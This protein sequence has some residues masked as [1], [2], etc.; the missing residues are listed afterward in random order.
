[1]ADLKTPK[2]Y[3][4]QV[5]GLIE[6]HNLVIQ[7]EQ[8]AMN[9]LSSVNYYRLSAYGIGLKKKDN[10]EHYEDGISF[11]HLYRLYEFD[12]K[13]RNLITPVIE[14]IEVEFRTRLAY[15]LALAYGAEGY[16]DPANFSQKTTKD[17][18][19]IHAYTI[20]KLDEEISH[21][22][23][24]PF[25]K[26]HMTKYGGH[27][28]IWA[29]AELFTFGMSCSLYDVCQVEDKKAIAATYQTKYVYLFAWMLS[30]SELR[31]KCA[32]YNRVYNIPFTKTPALYPNE[33]QYISNKLFPLLLAMKHIMGKR[34]LW[35]VFLDNLDKLMNEYPEAIPFYMGFP[36]HWQQVLK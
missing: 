32:H 12:S 24:L 30:I 7:D 33:S 2:C 17:G 34:D 26:H 20:H 31:N 11:D 14:W 5:R 23:Y 16:R 21:Q 28:P 3:K 1:M 35:A 4:C 18:K 25:V 27:F 15:H 22:Q 6:N 10:P 19:T 29:A 8:N 9:L 13:L 36:E